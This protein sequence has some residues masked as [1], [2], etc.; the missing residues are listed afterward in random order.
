MSKFAVIGLGNFG[1][2]VARTLFEAGHEVLAIDK[3]KERVQALQ[4]YTTQGVVADATNKKVL[5]QLGLGEMDAVVVNLGEDLGAAVLVTL[6]LRELKVKKVIVKIMNEDHR[7][8]LEKVGAS[9]IVFPEKDTAIKV[10]K[11]LISPNVLDYL[12]LS[13]DYSIAEWAPPKEFVGKTLSELRLRTRF[14]INVI[15]I[16]EIVPERMVINPPADFVIKDSDLLIILGHR[17]E[18]EKLK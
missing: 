10:A 1:H 13:P 11:G 18:V 16:R 14:G 3:E 4:N 9:E 5:E 8:V 17:S 2:T 6:F 12:P 15:A 7:R